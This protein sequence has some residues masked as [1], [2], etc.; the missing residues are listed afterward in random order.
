MTFIERNPMRVL[1]PL[2]TA[3]TLS[4]AL[5]PAHAGS[6]VSTE[7]PV[8]KRPYQLPPPADLVYTIR[9]RQHGIS[10]TGEAT[11]AWRAGDG[12]YSLST[13]SRVSLLGKILEQ[14]SEGTLD[15]YGL[16]PATFYEKRFRKD[17]STTRFQR[18]SLRIGFSDSDASYPLLGGEQDRGS[19]QWQ[20]AA[21]ARATPAQFKPG[22]EW[23]YFVAGRRDA[24]AWRFKV[25]E[26]EKISTGV[27]ELDTLHLVKAPPP[28]AQG[29]QVDLWL[30]PGLDWYPVR[31]RFNDSDGDFVEQTLD[32]LS[33]K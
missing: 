22:S 1:I 29:Q 3:L 13:S 16:A 31:I 8:A 27:G 17:P 10:L 7:H 2:L 19:A 6:D 24:E 32:K 26:R 25:I 15:G 28:D 11:V 23:S 20:L 9:A 14:R 33:R 18:D 4:T 21:Q 12:Q 5:I 30:A